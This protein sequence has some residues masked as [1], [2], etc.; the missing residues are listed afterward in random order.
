MLYTIFCAS[1]RTKKQAL[2]RCLC[3]CVCVL[4]FAFGVHCA[5]QCRMFSEWKTIERMPKFILFFVFFSLLHRQESRARWWLSSVILTIKW[6]TRK[7]TEQERYTLKPIITLWI[8]FS[9][10][11]LLPCMCALK[12]VF[13]HHK[14]NEQWIRRFKALVSTSIMPKWSTHICRLK[15]KKKSNFSLQKSRSKFKV[16]ASTVM[17]SMHKRGQ[18]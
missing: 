3:M 6:K 1:C 4:P 13:D 11:V 14:C 16:N 7:L 12:I 15:D 9:L 2:F 18:S 17:Q 8:L 5:T 10:F